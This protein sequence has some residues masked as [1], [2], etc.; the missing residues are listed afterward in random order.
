M[1][2]FQSNQE[3]TRARSNWCIMYLASW[4]RDVQR[5]VY[6][7]SN[8]CVAKTAHGKLQSNQGNPCSST[9]MASTQCMTW[10]SWSQ[11]F[12]QLCK[13]VASCNMT[14]SHVRNGGR[15]HFLCRDRY[16]FFFSW[17]EFVWGECLLCAQWHQC[18]RSLLWLSVISL[19]SVTS[20]NANILWLIRGFENPRVSDVSSLLRGCWIGWISLTSSVVGGWR[21]CECP[22]WGL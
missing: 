7:W 15:A 16:C 5:T 1:G 3:S 2:K 17:R 14:V 4:H 19:K 12:G 10:S 21:F 13:P 6:A 18:K 22:S 11:G 8:W 9:D 20:L